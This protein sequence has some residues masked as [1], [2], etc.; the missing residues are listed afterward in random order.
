[1]ATI[2]RATQKAEAAR[3]AA[4]EEAERRLRQRRCQRLARAAASRTA[5][6]DGNANESKPGLGAPADK[7]R[8]RQLRK[9]FKAHQ[10]GTAPLSDD[11]YQ[12]KRAEVASIRAAIA[13]RRDPPTET[14]CAED[15]AADAVKKEVVEALEADAAAR[16][17][18]RAIVQLAAASAT[19]QHGQPV[20]R[21]RRTTGLVTSLAKGEVFVFGSNEGGRHGKGAAK[22]ARQWGAKLG[23]AEG[24]QGDTYA[25]PTK[26]SS[27]SRTLSI[28]Q[29]RRYVTTFIA[30]ALE[31]PELTFLVT[32]IG[33]GLADL[34][35]ADVAPLFAAATR[36]D[37]VSLPASFWTELDHVS[38]NRLNES[39]GTGSAESLACTQEEQPSL[40][41]RQGP[42][43]HGHTDKPVPDRPHSTQ[44]QSQCLSQD[45]DHA[46]AKTLPRLD[47]TDAKRACAAC[48]RSLPLR[49]FSSSQRKK[50]A[51]GRC[52]VCVQ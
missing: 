35:A 5:E 15:D 17:Q 22:M 3:V 6:S 25:I 16:R 26:N 30:F 44:Q 52:R 37:N 7:E 43:H 10:A 31:H 23:Q 14:N 13:A 24:L 20:P 33:C 12:S 18:K 9:E 46:E 8:M 32:E 47:A 34:R 2:A 21:A 38:S 19:H 42:A 1:M 11:E 40:P 49:W 36:L 45:Q 48:K 29:I 41:R 4:E 28:S 39:C 50:G 27:V 51:A